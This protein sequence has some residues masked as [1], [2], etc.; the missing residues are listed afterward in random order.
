MGTTFKAYFPRVEQN[1]HVPLPLDCAI[2]PE[3]LRGHETLLLVEDETAVRHP[4]CEF[5]RQCGYAVIEGRDA[6]HAAEQAHQ[7]SG[8]IDLLITD[9]VM[10]GMS[11][12][13]LAE[14]LFDRYSE[15]KVLFMSGYSEK[16]VL[17][18][19]VSDLQTNFLQKPFT[20]KALAAKIREVLGHAAAAASADSCG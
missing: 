4:A 14:L 13:Q 1:A 19:K 17:R 9:V 8:R 2:D 20:L 5:L 16:V 3:S 10:P 6:L 11:G 12:G 7:H 18:H 15:M